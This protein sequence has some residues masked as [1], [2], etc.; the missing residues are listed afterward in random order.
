MLVL[1]TDATESAC[2]MAGSAVGPFY[3]P[4]DQ[5]VYLD[6]AFFR[7][8]ESDKPVATPDAVREA[9]PEP[10]GEEPSQPT[11]LAR[12]DTLIEID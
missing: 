3:C 4:R 2:G 7:I 8:Y 11:T 6:V 10:R 5:R 9:V 12:R 1:F